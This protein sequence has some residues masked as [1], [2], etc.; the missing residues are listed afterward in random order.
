MNDVADLEHQLYALEQQFLGPAARSSRKNLEE[1]S[2]RHLG[3]RP[4]KSNCVVHRELQGKALG[5]GCG[6]RHL[7]RNEERGRVV[8]S[9][10]R[11]AAQWRA[12]E[13][14]VSPGHEVRKMKVRSSS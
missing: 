7:C 1:L 11:L 10:F 14:G 6:A 4:G 3:A 12:V 9:L 8:A 13:N 5:R 2:E